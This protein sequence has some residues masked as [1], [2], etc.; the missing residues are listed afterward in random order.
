VAVAGLLTVYGVPGRGDTLLLEAWY[1]SLEVRRSGTA[2]TLRP[3]TDGLIGGRYRG[4]LAATGAYTPAARPFVPDGVAEVVDLSRALDDLFPI[5]AARPLGIGQRW[6]HS[7]GLEIRR[8]P[9]SVAGDTLLL[10]RASLARASDS[11]TPSGD[12]AAIPARQTTREDE[13]FAWHPRRGLVRRSRTIIVETTI[14][15]GGTVGRPVRSRVEQHIV[16]ERVP[17]RISR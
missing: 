5:L 11:V 13:R 17:A 12:S 4:R 9:D 6:S 8:L 10:F 16:V 3:D 2:G 15:G 1:D 7:S 14:P